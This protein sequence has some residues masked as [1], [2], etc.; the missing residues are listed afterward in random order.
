MKR[1]FSLFLA[2]LLLSTSLLALSSCGI[3][4]KGAEISVY[5]SDEIYDF[6]PAMSYTDDNSVMLISML[7]EPL[8]TLDENGRLQMAAAKDYYFDRDTGDLYIELRESYWSGSED[9]RVLAGDFASRG[10]AARQHPR[11]LAR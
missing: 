11:Y 10:H 2:L 7:F 6:D 9:S 5:L 3:E 4:G 1:L 8:F